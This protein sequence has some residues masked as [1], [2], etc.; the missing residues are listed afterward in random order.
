MKT[1]KLTAII[2]FIFIQYQNLFSY[3][4]AITNPCVTGEFPTPFFH[5]LNSISVDFRLDTFHITDSKFARCKI[6]VLQGNR[7]ELMYNEIVEAGI[8]LST[9]IDPQNLT[10]FG[11]NEPVEIKI[12]ATS[13]LFPNLPFSCSAYAIIY[14][15]GMSRKYGSITGGTPTL[16]NEGPAT[17]FSNNDCRTL[18]SGIYFIKQYMLTFT[19]T[20]DFTDY[21]PEVDKDYCLGYDGSL[22]NFQHR[23][24]YKIS[25]TATEAKFITMVYKAYN[26]LGQEFVYFPADIE[27][28]TI[29]YHLVSK[30]AISGFV[31]YPSVLSPGSNTGF[32]MCELLRG[33]DPVTYEWRDSNNIHN[34]QIINF[35]ENYPYIMIIGNLNNINPRVEN[36]SV[37]GRA[38]N[39]FGYSEWKK[40][41]VRFGDD[42]HGCPT[43][44]TEIEGHQIKDNPVFNKSP[45]NPLKDITD[46]YI[47][48]DPTLE[49]RD[50][51]DFS[52]LENGIENTRVDKLE[53]NMVTA[54]KGKEVS[55]TEDGEVIDYT[56]DA[57]KNTALL[58]YK[59]D[60]TDILKFQD[61]DILDFRKNDKLEINFLP[62]KY[63]SYIVMRIR[64]TGIKSNDAAVIKTSSSEIVSF[65]CRSNFSK[66]AI[67]VKPDGFNGFKMTGLEDCE[68][69]QIA[70]VSN[71]NENRTEKLNLIV[72][73]NESGKIDKHIADAD[74][75]YAYISKDNA[76]R[77]IFKNNRD[78]EKKSYYFIKLTGGYKPET[79]EIKVNS[80]NPDN[81]YKFE[82]SDNIPNP[83]N[84]VTKIKYEL[85]QAGFVKMAVYDISGREVRLLTNEFKS[86]GQYE[87]IFNSTD[88]QGSSLSSGVY[89][90]KIQSGGLS[91][92]KRM[93]LIK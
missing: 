54:D 88:E 25:Q 8:N 64:T 93:I 66:I 62:D 52:I 24:G 47:L 9:P 69:D 89:F 32:I 71:N 57:L 80:D 1:L 77:F 67:K 41:R 60:V 5:P 17:F 84:P 59:D 11:Y 55:V 30:P 4:V 14:K 22:P 81:I 79:E 43:V 90:Y 29:V 85:P 46:Y 37:S 73:Y 33:T 12:T 27:K 20:G 23:W 19:L 48:N 34:H 28:V 82:L 45:D 42:P 63:D 15:N 2:F 49:S 76:A 26:V 74:N 65:K 91:L 18:S 53:M 68:I 3:G 87:V 16:L 86:A 6:Y 61:N 39:Q 50:S 83:F 36:F 13:A 31:Q 51:I 38:H 72:A 40:Y 56:V 21:F 44:A 75:V 10:G 58:N 78:P 70:V 7:Q 92:T 35:G